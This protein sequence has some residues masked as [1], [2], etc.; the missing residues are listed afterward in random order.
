[1]PDDERTG[2]GVADERTGATSEEIGANAPAPVPTFLDRTYRIVEEVSDDIVSWSEPAG[3]S[4]IIKQV[5]RARLS[6]ARRNMHR[7]VLGR[8]RRDSRRSTTTTTHSD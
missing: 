4:F 5:K 3:D 7:N 8:V 2:A 1:M 6:S